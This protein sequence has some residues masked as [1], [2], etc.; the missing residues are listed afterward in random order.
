MLQ[1]DPDR[2]TEEERTAWIERVKLNGPTDVRELWE[3][4]V[5]K[6]QTLHAE[7]KDRGEI[8]EEIVGWVRDTESLYRMREYRNQTILLI[9]AMVAQ[10]IDGTF[11]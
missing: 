10:A 5:A 3:W 11:S 7:G 9:G 2:L 8:R 4:I 6:V 1:F